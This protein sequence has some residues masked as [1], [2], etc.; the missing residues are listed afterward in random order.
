M[1]SVE[2]YVDRFIIAILSSN[3][4]VMSELLSSKEV[5]PNEKLIN[6]NSG[7]SFL[8][9]T[10]NLFYAHFVSFRQ[11]IT[12]NDEKISG[13]VE[14]VRIL[15]NAGANTTGLISSNLDWLLFCF[16]PKNYQFDIL[17]LF[18]LHD[19][20]LNEPDNNVLFRV[21]EYDGKPSHEGN[22]L[23]LRKLMFLLLSRGAAITSKFSER[24]HPFIHII[25]SLYCLD[26]KGCINFM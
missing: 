11:A 1:Q 7:K 19:E 3:H 12:Y 4:A 8:Q 9:F 24:S 14:S 2:I 23:R 5:D 22:S 6:N 25:L 20:K 10:L 21:I 15:V 18:A 16:H 13:I 17:D 26:R